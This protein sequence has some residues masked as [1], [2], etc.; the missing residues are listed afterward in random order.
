VN[1]EK[2]ERHLYEEKREILF[3]MKKS[4]SRSIATAVEQTRDELGWRGGSVYRRW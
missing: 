3:F 1:F 2:P 4:K